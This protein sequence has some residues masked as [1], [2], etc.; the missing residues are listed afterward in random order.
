MKYNRNHWEHMD[1]N[2]L[3]QFVVEI[4]NY[5]RSRGFPFYNLTIDQQFEEL[6]KMD[7]YYNSTE[8]IV[9]NKIKQTMHCLNVAWTYFD[10]AWSVRCHN[11]ISP[12]EAFEDDKKFQA[13]IRRRLKRGSYISDSGLRKGLRVSS[14]IQAVSNFRPTAARAIYDHYGGDGIVWDMSCGYGGRLLGAISSRRVKHYIGTDPDTLTHS[15]LLKMVENLGNWN[16]ASL[17]ADKNNTFINIHN[18]GSEVFRPDKD[19]LDLCF[20][21]PPYFNTEKYS[22]EDSQSYLKFPT[23]KLWLKNFLMKTIEHCVYGLKVG[24][25]LLINI[26]NVKTYQDLETAFVE[27]VYSMF[28]QL[29]Q[30]QTMD[31]LLSSSNTGGFKSEHIFVFQKEL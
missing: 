3:D 6:N 21:S 4:F 22:T 28:P 24:G 1:D 23:K 31:Y 13:V 10:H 11:Q 29:I 5:Y 12:M 20:T 19:S 25:F 9:D 2:T 18:V 15:G 17:F 30:K 7:K 26:S 16:R 14:G 8:I 27:S